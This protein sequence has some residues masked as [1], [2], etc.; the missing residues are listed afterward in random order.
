M[1]FSIL[2]FIFIFLSACGRER[3][4]V[5]KQVHTSSRTWSSRPLSV[6]T[7]S[8][9]RYIKPKADF[10]FLWDNSSSTNHLDETTK[11]A[12]NNTVRMISSEY[13]FRILLAPLVTSTP[14]YVSEMKL[15]ADNPKSLSS[16][17]ISL[18]IP[19]ERA[20]ERLRTFPQDSRSVEAGLQRAIEL[21][22]YGR[23]SNIFRRDSKMHV[24]LMSNQ[25]DNSWHNKNYSQQAGTDRINYIK[26]RV[27]DFKK[28]KKDHSFQTLRLHSIVNA[29]RE[30]PNK[31]YREVSRQLYNHSGASGGG[32]HPDSF[33]ICKNSFINIFAS[34]NASVQQILVPHKYNYW[35]V[36]SS[37][38]CIEVRDI[39]VFK[40]KTIS[41]P[42]SSSNGF[43]FENK[44]QTKDTRYH[45]DKGEPFSGYLI[46]LH[47][48]AE[49][50]HPECLTVKTI[51]PKDCFDGIAL[52]F[53]PEEKTIEVYINGLK[54]DPVTASNP[55]GWELL[56]ESGSEKYFKSYNIKAD[57]SNPFCRSIST[58][59][60][61]RFA[62][63]KRS[64]YILKLRNMI[65][66]NNDD[67]E[68]LFDPLSEL[69]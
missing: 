49:V 37:S 35:P 51:K 41:V 27:D 45:P 54:I 14:G 28:L 36:A 68:V 56:K 55:K 65:Y 18:L 62:E 39:Q 44:V 47:G 69:R 25:D 34:I 20:A 59:C 33:D 57:T 24:V 26:A 12:L 40:N 4:G 42:N 8:S 29:C 38:A 53:R 30:T 5:K 10:L 6:E 46:K 22:K 64:G 21:I 32:A 19:W 23:R 66:T 61:K 1:R 63:D 16:S 17:S 60:P 58:D 48:A 11:T 43:T 13:D 15:V 50:V 9:F 52:P 3:I 2:V 67:V 7:C 31:V